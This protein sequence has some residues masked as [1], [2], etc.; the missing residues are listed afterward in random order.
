MRPLTAYHI[1]FQIEREWI[2]QTTAGPDADKSIHDKKSYLPDVPRRYRCIRLLPDWYAGPGKRKKRKHR[3]SH[4]KIG[5]LEL[6]SLVSKRWK[7]LSTTDPE[8]KRF[9]TKIAGRE[10]AE[11]KVEMEEYK[12]LTEGTP[13]TS[14]KIAAEPVV[15]ASWD[16][17]ESASTRMISPSA[18]PRPDYTYSSSYS[19]QNE[20][21]SA[22]YYMPITESADLVLSLNQEFG[23]DSSSS[24]SVTEAEVDYSICSVGNNGNYIPSP[25]SASI[26]SEESICDPLFELDNDFISAE[27][28]C[29]K[30]CVSPVVSASGFL[31]QFSV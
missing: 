31:Q 4:G 14:A 23:T 10:L 1:F 5:F 26:C 18:S 6:S 25:G 19:P 11:Y 30:R 2:I 13:L 29:M 28:S 15:S 7:N 17:V 24:S 12:Y 9:V 8:T 22:E 21:L 20:V 16:A 27:Q 3:K